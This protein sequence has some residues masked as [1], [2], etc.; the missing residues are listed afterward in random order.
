M[1]LDVNLL[2]S[3]IPLLDHPLQGTNHTNLWGNMQQ[4]CRQQF[5]GSLKC[6]LISF[7]YYCFFV[8][9]GKS[10][11]VARDQAVF[12]KVI[13]SCCAWLFSVGELGCSWSSINSNHWSSK[14][15]LPLRIKENSSP[16]T[17]FF[18]PF[19]FIPAIIHS[20]SHTYFKMC[21]SGDL[22]CW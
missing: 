4:P 19:H 12:Q 20:V 22:L 21:T 8:C 7:N 1:S 2:F 15:L 5:Y 14:M 17:F 16:S 3:S 9:D 13:T 6:N 11:A 18:F 10:F